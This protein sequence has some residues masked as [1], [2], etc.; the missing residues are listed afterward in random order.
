M[1]RRKISH[2]NAL[3][4]AARNPPIMILDSAKGNVLNLKAL[5]QDFDLLKGLLRLK[6]LYSV[7]LPLIDRTQP[8]YHLHPTGICRN[9]MW[10]HGQI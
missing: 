4:D 6:F 8:H 9:S 1:H 7:D 2:L 5:S 10:A 3:I